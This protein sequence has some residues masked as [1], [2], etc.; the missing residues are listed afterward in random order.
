MVMLSLLYVESLHAHSV[1]FLGLLC[2]VQSSSHAE[3]GS[4]ASAEPSQPCCLESYCLLQ[5]F[6][7]YKNYHFAPSPQRGLH[8]CILHH[9]TYPDNSFPVGNGTW[10]NKE[11]MAAANPKIWTRRRRQILVSYIRQS[12]SVFNTPRHCSIRLSDIF[13]EWEDPRSQ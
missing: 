2:V 1:A 4:Q 9:V 7:R 11:R 6:S 5:S 12:R 8:S 13:Q 3:K 10:F